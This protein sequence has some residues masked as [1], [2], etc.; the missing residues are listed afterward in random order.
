MA[1]VPPGRTVQ[2]RHDEPSPLRVFEGV[3]MLTPLRDYATTHHQLNFGDAPPGRTP[4]GFSKQFVAYTCVCTR[5]L[6]YQ[7][8]AKSL[9]ILMVHWYSPNLM[10]RNIFYIIGVIVVIIVVLKVLGLF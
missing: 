10:N 6:E 1:R 5:C 4:N 9:A 7:H 2:V 3:I 8:P